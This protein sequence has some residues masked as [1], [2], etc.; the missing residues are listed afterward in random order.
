MARRKKDKPPP[1]TE[2]ELHEWEELYLRER[3]RVL[4]EWHSYA[5]SDD[6]V[7]KKMAQ[8]RLGLQLRIRDARTMQHA[9]MLERDELRDKG[10]I[11]GK[12]EAAQKLRH[13]HIV[14]HS[15]ESEI[16]D[17][18]EKTKSKFALSWTQQPLTLE[19]LLE[20]PELDRATNFGIEGLPKQY[21]SARSAIAKCRTTIDS[22]PMNTEEVDSETAAETIVSLLDGKH[23]KQTTMSHDVLSQSPNQ[24]Q[25]PPNPGIEPIIRQEQEKIWA[26]HEQA[27]RAVFTNMGLLK[28]STEARLAIQRQTYLDQQ[29]H[30]IAVRESYNQVLNAI[31]QGHRVPLGASS[32]RFSRGGHW[33]LAS[34]RL[35]SYFEGD[36]NWKQ[37]GWVPTG[38][39]IMQKINGSL[40]G[41]LNFGHRTFTF[42]GIRIPKVADLQTVDAVAFCETS[43]LKYDFDIIF[44]PGDLLKVLFPALPL[45]LRDSR[46]KILPTMHP[47]VDFSAVTMRMPE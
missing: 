11:E 42:G 23:T 14:I 4:R 21:P 27:L 34:T 2:E 24:E 28:I 41:F 26:K 13:I 7:V 33:H 31:Q 20:N 8:V 35:W 16:G 30:E 15:L 46:C 40:A 44:L 18:K 19:K 47:V 22:I 9:L 12:R 3:S 6:P 29:E 1:P 5:H 32:S 45:V 37:A 17:M 39:L 43:G 10:D 25:L 36:E 38:N